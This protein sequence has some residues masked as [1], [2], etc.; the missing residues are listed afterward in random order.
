MLVWLEELS[1]DVSESESSSRG[2]FAPCIGDGAMM[3]AVVPA[4]VEW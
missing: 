2:R 4:K 1:S 3:D